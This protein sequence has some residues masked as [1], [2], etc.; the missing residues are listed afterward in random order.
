MQKEHSFWDR[1][2][3]RLQTSR[4]LPYQRRGARP[5]QEGFPGA[6][7]GAILVPRSLKDYSVQVRVWTTEATQLL[8]Q[9]KLTQI[10]G[11]AVFQAFIFCQEA[12]S[13]TRYLCTFPATGELA[14]REYSDH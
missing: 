2:R 8:G 11:Q 1:P 3:F 14:S 7:G 5:T 4:K 10:L 12:G 9:V 13:N 6:P